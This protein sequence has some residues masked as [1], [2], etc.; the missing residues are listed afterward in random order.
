M[1]LAGVKDFFRVRL[2]ALSYREWPD[3]FA[4]NNI[5]STLL[6]KAYHLGVGQINVTL[7]NQ[8]AHEFTYP[9]S[10]KVFLKGYRDPS[11]AIDAAL[12]E[13]HVIMADLLAPAQRLQSEGLKSLRLTSISPSPLQTG[14][15]NAVVLE[16]NF[17]AFLIFD[18]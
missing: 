11:A 17:T 1:T 15:D 8:K 6:D 18:F 9:L 4:T 13:A 16:L 7:P 12:T 10:L 2:D 14:N 5:P 3:G